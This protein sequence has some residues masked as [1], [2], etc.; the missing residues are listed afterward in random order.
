MRRPRASGNPVALI[1]RLWIPASAGMTSY[2]RIPVA[3]CSYDLEV[4]LQLPIGHS[5]EPLPPFPVARGREVV[6]EIV[7]EPVTGDLRSLEVARGFDQCAR[8]ARDVLAAD[9]GAFDRFYRELEFLLHAIESSREARR[10]SE[11]RVHVGPGA[12]RFQTRCLGA[13]G[14]D[15]EARGPV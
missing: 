12:A 8:C 9:V 10:G 13:R 2:R 3:Y 11:I 14:D 1:E 4:P 5:V 7:A 15:A 6:D